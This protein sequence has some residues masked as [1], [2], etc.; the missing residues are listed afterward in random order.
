MNPNVE[1]LVKIRPNTIGAASRTRTGVEVEGD[2]WT[3]A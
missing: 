2:V 3:C 1:W